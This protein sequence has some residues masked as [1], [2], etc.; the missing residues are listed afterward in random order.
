[1]VSK[2]STTDKQVVSTSATNKTAELSEAP[3]DTTVSS[4]RKSGE[5]TRKKIGM[6]PSSLFVLK[7][8]ASRKKVYRTTTIQEKTRVTYQEETDRTCYKKA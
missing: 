8:L 4:G 1:M 5:P 6:D 7:T 3:N 2:K